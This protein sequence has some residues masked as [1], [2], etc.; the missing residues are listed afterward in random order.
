MIVSPLLLDEVRR[1]LS[2]PRFETP[3]AL[4]EAFEA[5]IRHISLLEH[6]PPSTGAVPASA[7]P[8]DNYLIRITLA[9]SA[10]LLVTGDRHL[11]D[12]VGR[13]PVVTPRELLD[14]LSG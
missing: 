4:L 5:H 14:A 12:L 10:R 11:L 8:K 13:V 1:V 6:D 2:R 3:P 7:D 9:S